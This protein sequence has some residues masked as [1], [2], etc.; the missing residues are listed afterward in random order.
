MYGVVAALMLLVLS[1]TLSVRLFLT[2]PTRPEWLWQSHVN[3]AD[4]K[5]TPEVNAAL[6]ALFDKL[7]ETHWYPWYQYVT[8]DECAANSVRQHLTYIVS[9]LVCRI[10]NNNNGFPF[11]IQA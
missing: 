1:L 9:E 4:L 7:L 10:C 11:L 2:A 8:K 3:R 6:E 5:V